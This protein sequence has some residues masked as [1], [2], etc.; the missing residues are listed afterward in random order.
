MLSDYYFVPSAILCSGGDQSCLMMDEI[1]GSGCFSYLDKLWYWYLRRSFC[2]P[3]VQGH[4]SDL[5]VVFELRRFDLN[6]SIQFGYNTWYLCIPAN[7]LFPPCLYQ[8]RYVGGSL[9]NK[10]DS[11]YK[12]V[13]LMS[14]IFLQDLPTSIINSIVNSRE[15]ILQAF[16]WAY[17]HVPIL[18]ISFFSISRKKFFATHPILEGFQI[19]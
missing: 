13:Y 17:S 5:L 7:Q 11:G 4:Q 2:F 19:I 9:N 14:S 12:I 10:W 16:L 15:D 8:V 6:Q 1:D 3:F 18:N